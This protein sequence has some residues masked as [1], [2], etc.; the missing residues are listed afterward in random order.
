MQRP[1]GELEPIPVPDSAGQ[2]PT[3]HKAVSGSSGNG[4]ACVVYL[5]LAMFRLLSPMPPGRRDGLQER[6]G[7]R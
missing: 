6:R 3:A 2:C 5:L 7:P 1:S 4:S